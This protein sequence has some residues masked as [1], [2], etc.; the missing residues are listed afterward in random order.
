MRNYQI[1]RLNQ[2]VIMS[3]DT[4]KS[5]R[6]YR[7]VLGL[8]QK[9]SYDGMFFLEI[10]ETT[11]MIHPTKEPVNPNNSIGIEFS[12][13]NVNALVEKVKHEEIGKVVQEP[14][15]REWGVR[16]AIVK[17]PDGYEVWF[18]QRLNG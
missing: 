9:E 5:V 15:D 7:D 3:Q 1:T 8:P 12:V 18:T 10:G 13:D 2:V 11:L 16:E 14:V 4:E 17:D 6:F